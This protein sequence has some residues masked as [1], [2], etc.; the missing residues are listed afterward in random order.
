MG[1]SNWLWNLIV[2]E[3]GSDYYSILE[4]SNDI[5]CFLKLLEEDISRGNSRTFPGN[6]FQKMEFHGTKIRKEKRRARLGLIIATLNMKFNRHEEKLFHLS[7]FLVEV[8]KT[9]EELWQM[10]QR[11]VRANIVLV[12]SGQKERIRKNLR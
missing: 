1:V 8:E 10:M 11:N 5:R 2:Y 9:K 6:V 7:E 3:E 12:K 4:L